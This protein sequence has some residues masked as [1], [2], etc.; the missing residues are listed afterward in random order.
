MVYLTIMSNHILTSQRVLAMIEYNKEHGYS[1]AHVY[2]CQT[3]CRALCCHFEFADL[4]V[5]FCVC[6]NSY[7]YSLAPTIK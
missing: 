3:F 5:I 1:L 4:C 7:S 6:D 2:P